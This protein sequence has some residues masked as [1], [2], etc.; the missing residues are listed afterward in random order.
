MCVCLGGSLAVDANRCERR[1]EGAQ[2]NECTA[3]DA[4]KIAEHDHKRKERSED[5]PIHGAGVWEKKKQ[6][7]EYEHM[8]G[9]QT[10]DDVR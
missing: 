6:K 8:Q 5:L 7:S 1:E 9:A 3:E 4:R 2:K 10:Q